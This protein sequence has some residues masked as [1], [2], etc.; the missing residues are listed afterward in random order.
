MDGESIKKLKVIAQTAQP[1]E[2]ATKLSSFQPAQCINDLNDST[3]LV[4][5]WCKWILQLPRKTPKKHNDTAKQ[6]ILQKKQPK[7]SIPKHK[8]LTLGGLEKS[9]SK[10][11]P[12]S[13]FNK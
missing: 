7:Q 12:L 8:H 13:C 9:I 3:S 1:E 5:Q 4:M 10:N 2:C 11:H 6:T